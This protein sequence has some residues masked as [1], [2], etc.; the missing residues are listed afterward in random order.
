MEA[1]KF[2]FF[3]IVKIQRMF[4]RYKKRRQDAADRKAA[5]MENQNYD[6][7]DYAEDTDLDLD[8]E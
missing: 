2:P 5:L 7:F 4:R 1:I 8:E 6:V 3:Q